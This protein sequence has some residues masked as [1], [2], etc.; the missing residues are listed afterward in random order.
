MQQNKARQ[1]DPT[2]VKLNLLKTKQTKEA[3][4]CK[5]FLAFSPN[6]YNYFPVMLRLFKCEVGGDRA[7][8]GEIHRGVEVSINSSVLEG[9]SA[10]QERESNLVLIL[11]E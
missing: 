5:D 10:Y 11:A 7:R 3:R 4:P 2:W 8:N 9:Q 6:C 1:A